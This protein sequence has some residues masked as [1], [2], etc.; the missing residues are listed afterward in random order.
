MC[1]RSAVKVMHSRHSAAVLHDGGE[2]ALT[3]GNVTRA[4]AAAT[5]VKAQAAAVRAAST[6]VT[7]VPERIM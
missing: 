1:D 5:A 4:Q 3:E 6:A 7:T 2:G